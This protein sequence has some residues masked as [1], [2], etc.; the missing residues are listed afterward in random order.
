MRININW[1]CLANGCIFLCIVLIPFLGRAQNKNISAI[2]NATFNEQE[3]FL[4]AKTIALESRNIEALRSL[5]N[6]ES[7][8][9]SL[10]NS[11]YPEINFHKIFSN[12][13]LVQLVNSLQKQ[14]SENFDNLSCEENILLVSSIDDRD[15]L[16]SFSISLPYFFKGNDKADYALFYKQKISKDG[17][18]GAGSFLLFKKEGEKWIDIFVFP[19]YIA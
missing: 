13:D 10:A 9:E 8:K 4:S 5:S 7:A 11:Q 17:L 18:T 3:V 19:L 14:E 2:I 6:W 12:K 16:K 15:F 1:F